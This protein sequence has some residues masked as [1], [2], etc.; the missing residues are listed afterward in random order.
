M[1]KWQNQQFVRGFPALFPLDATTGLPTTDQLATLLDMYF[2]PSKVPHTAT[3]R[4]SI[5]SFG[6]TGSDA[7]DAKFNFNQYIRE[8]GD[9]KIHNLTE[10]IANSTFWNDPNP[11]M[12]Q[13]PLRAGQ[14]GPR[15]DAGHGQ[16][17]PEPL[18]VAD[19]GPHLLRADW[20]STPS[21]PPRATSRRAS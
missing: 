18:R 9:A 21:S 1:P 10:L 2:D 15:D 17:H 6:G 7:G 4:P 16:R 19:R 3:G 13:P 11:A 20:T 14:H 8:R 12:R 5:R